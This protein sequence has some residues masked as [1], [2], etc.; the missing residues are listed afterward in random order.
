FLEIKAWLRDIK[1]EE[2]TTINGKLDKLT[3]RME[4]A[5]NRV[6][7]REDRLYHVENLAAEIHTLGEKCDDLENRS[8]RSNLRIVG[9]PEGLEGRN[10]EKFAVNLITTVLGEGGNFPPKT[11][12][13]TSRRKG[14]SSRR[15]GNYAIPRTYLSPCYTQPNLGRYLRFRRTD[16]GAKSRWKSIT[17]DS[18]ALWEY[19]FHSQVHDTFSRIDLVLFSSSLLCRVE[20]CSYLPRSISDHSPLRVVMDFP[21]IP[22]PDHR[23]RLNPRFLTTEESVA[24]V[25]RLIDEYL[26]HNGPSSLTPDFVWEALKATLRGHI[27]SHT[28][29]C[30]KKHRA[31]MLNL[32]LELCQ[33]ETED[34]KCR[35][36]E[37]RE[38]VVRARHDLNM[39]S[40]SK[41]EEALMRTKSKYYVRGD[42][43]GKLLAWQLRKVELERH[44]SAIG[45]PESN[46]SGDP[47]I[48][49]KEFAS[50]YSSLYTSESTFQGSGDRMSLFLDTL[51][52]PTLS[53]ED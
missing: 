12:A 14:G 43:A 3:H 25:G 13:W 23:W 51:S 32:E 46:L 11:L 41:A 24:E 37:S 18:L 47:E 10:P 5:E 48:I 38:R 40:T 35:S 6:G 8:R 34:Y 30:K 45:S 4:T 44:V 7:E 33:A 9:V 16:K 36:A 22:P 17:G 2:M 15:P 20:P 53:E 28:V 26:I 1:T 27:I 49:N 21:E 42:K 19:S 31:Q 39:I 50:Y 29:A 52:I